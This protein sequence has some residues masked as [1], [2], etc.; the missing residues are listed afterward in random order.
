MKLLLIKAFAEIH[1][2]SQFV[3]SL[4]RGLAELGHEVVI[5]DQ[6][7]HVVDGVAPAQEL[8][9][10]LQLGRFE[11]CVSFSSFFGG[12]TLD[13][14]VSLFD[15]LGI[16]FLGWQLDHPIYAPHSLARA[17]QGRYAVYSNHNHLRFA[18]ALKLP[19]RGTTMLLGA[20]P[21]QAP[22][23]GY[24]E[25][26]WPVFIAASFVGRPQALWEQAEESVGKRL[27]IGVV[28]RLMAD[29]EA[30]LLEAFNATSDGLSLGVRFGVD[31]GLDD[32]LV[33]LLREPLTYVRQLDRI[34]IVEAL[35]QSG[36]P[37]AVSG[38]G[39]REILG[40]RDNVTH[41]DSWVAFKDIADHYNDAKIVINLNAGNGACERATYA[42]LAGAAVVSDFSADLVAQFEGPGE[43]ALYDRAAPQ[44]ISD[45]VR[46]LIESD[47]GEAM[48]HNG[49]QRILTSG[50]VRHRAQQIVD[51]LATA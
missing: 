22:L 18:Q 21:P 38:P 30:S 9:R 5:S 7:V 34:R 23:K 39:W 43:I 47:A 40:E 44:G 14:G 32:Q 8:A 29:R 28:E 4:G 51:F 3:E 46:N 19:G 33:A 42:A 16:K 36:L 41:L 11:A 2:Y 27:L 10:E 25:R 45:L 15:A 37:V 49:R 12:V 1:A 13:N 6:S 35:A 20:E 48:A 26:K 31:P 50:L 17:L 24:H